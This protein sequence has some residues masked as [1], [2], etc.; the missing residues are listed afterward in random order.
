VLTEA[1][2]GDTG[3]MLGCIDADRTLSYHIAIPLLPTMT[4]NEAEA[5][6][7]VRSVS[8]NRSPAYSYDVD[9]RMSASSADSPDYLGPVPEYL[10]CS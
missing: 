8:L 10:S 7:S 2:H 1:T 4:I 3:E 6:T 9:R 5:R